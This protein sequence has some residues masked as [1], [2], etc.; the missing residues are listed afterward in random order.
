MFATNEE[1][2]HELKERR[3]MYMEGFKE[4][5]VKGERFS[6]NY[7]LK[8]KKSQNKNTKQLQSKQKAMGHGIFK[9]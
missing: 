6:L 9:G 3:E 4:R 1:R 8:E 2:G 7:S 5:I